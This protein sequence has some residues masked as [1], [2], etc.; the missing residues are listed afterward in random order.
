[1]ATSFVGETAVHRPNVSS[2]IRMLVTN[3]R[4]LSEAAGG[5]KPGRG[6]SGPLGAF[7]RAV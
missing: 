3:G 1:M 6:Y 4:T 7:D 2:A 5:R